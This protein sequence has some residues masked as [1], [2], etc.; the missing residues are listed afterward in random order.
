MPQLR[1]QNYK[2]EPPF[3]VLARMSEAELCE[4][5]DFRVENEHG[6]VTFV[7]FTDLRGLDLD[8]LVN[9]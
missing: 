8:E 1:R 2:I 9:I 4:V 7:G 3:E 5:E 6:S